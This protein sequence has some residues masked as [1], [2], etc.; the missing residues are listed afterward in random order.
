[1][2]NS[3]V[4]KI[5]PTA[6]LGGY[7]LPASSRFRSVRVKFMNAANALLTAESGQKAVQ[8]GHQN[9]PL[10]RRGKQSQSKPMTTT[11]GTG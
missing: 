4:G 7:T 6:N 8:S 11:A 9:Q 2:T 5:H 1:M 10:L 3:D